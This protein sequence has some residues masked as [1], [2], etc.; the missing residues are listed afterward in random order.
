MHGRFL[1]P[2]GIAGLIWSGLALADV[3]VDGVPVTTSRQGAVAIRAG[4]CRVLARHHPAADVTYAPGVD[5]EGRPVPPADLDAYPDLGERAHGFG[6]AVIV[7][8]GDRLGEG[9]AGQ[10]RP[11]NG[12]GVLG[13]IEIRDGTAYWEGKPLDANEIDAVNAACSRVLDQSEKDR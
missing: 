2:V 8:L 4:D 5:V 1:V 6:F 13:Y 7:D 3:S 11:F 10:A 12:E 9:G